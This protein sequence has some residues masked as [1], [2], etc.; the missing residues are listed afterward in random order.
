MV[1]SIHPKKKQLVAA[2][3]S[4]EYYS[5]FNPPSDTGIVSGVCGN[6]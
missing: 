4:F 3:L 5:R 2:F 6:I 1:K